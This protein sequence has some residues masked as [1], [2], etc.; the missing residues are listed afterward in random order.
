MKRNENFVIKELMGSFVLVPVGDTA[1]DFNGVIT[2]NDTAKYLWE[3]AEGDFD[4]D[5]LTDALIKEYDIDIGTA[6]EGAEIFITKMKE[7]GCIE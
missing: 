7:A 5:T 2:I 4:A 3:A 1:I 6:T